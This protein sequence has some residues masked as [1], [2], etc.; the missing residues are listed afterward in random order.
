MYKRQALKGTGTMAA[1]ELAVKAAGDTVK[2]PQHRFSGIVE[3]AI[4]RIKEEVVH[5]MPQE[6]QRW[7][8][9]KLFERDNKVIKQL[10]LSKDA[11]EHIEEDIKAAEIELDD[12]SESIITNERYIYISSIIKTCYKKKNRGSLTTSDKIDK[13]V[14]NRWAA[15]RCV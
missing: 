10:G 11:A 1:A 5:N 6:Q 9:V 7:Y 14:T 12:D 8:A 3:H 2:E 15:L 13:V 4:A